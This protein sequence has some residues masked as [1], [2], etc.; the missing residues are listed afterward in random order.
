[1]VDEAIRKVIKD[2]PFE[3]ALP[4]EDLALAISA[5]F[6]GIELLTHVGW[7]FTEIAAARADGDARTALVYFPGVGQKKLLV[8]VAGLK[9]VGGAVAGR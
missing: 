3:E 5:T 7:R 4:V 9:V 6:L 1:M 2:S 8:K